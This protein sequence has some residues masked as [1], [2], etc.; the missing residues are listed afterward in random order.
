MRKLTQYPKHSLEEMTG[1][2][3]PCA[4]TEYYPISV[5]SMHKDHI[6]DGTIELFENE[7]DGVIFFNHT[8]QEEVIK[9][10]EVPR[11]SIIGFISDV[12]GIIGV[13]LGLSFWSLHTLILE[14]LI[15]KLEKAVCSQYMFH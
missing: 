7:T 9:I 12:G 13:F 3:Q 4:I 11:Y 6:R 15:K 10:D 14:P 2:Q 1:C 5:V 8:P